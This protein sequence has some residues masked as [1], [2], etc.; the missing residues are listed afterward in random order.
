MA[1]KTSKICLWDLIYPLNHALFWQTS[2]SVV[3]ANHIWT[4]EILHYWTF[5][6]HSTDAKYV[7]IIMF[8][9]KCVSYSVWM[10]KQ[11]NGESE[12]PFHKSMNGYDWNQDLPLTKLQNKS[13][14]ILRECNFPSTFKRT[15]NV[16]CSKVNLS[17][18]ICLKI[19]F[20]S[21]ILNI[22]FHCLP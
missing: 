7:I 13:L 18:Q 5:N 12:P 10:C 4:S 22:L 2:V 15:N 17:Y 19:S 11:F 8:Y 16:S 6:N 14:S 9:G 20:F 21:L 3:E 1:P